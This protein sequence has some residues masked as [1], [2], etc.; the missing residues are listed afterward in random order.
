VDRFQQVK[1]QAVALWNSSYLGVDSSAIILIAGIILTTYL[2]RRRGPA[3]LI[4]AVGRV[5]PPDN[6]PS[7]KGALDTTRR[8]LEVVV[9]VTG[10]MLAARVLGIEPTNDGI[11]GL[12]IRSGVIIMVFWTLARLV[13]PMLTRSLRHFG[14]AGTELILRDFA[15][16][17]LRFLFIML[18]LSAVLEVWGIHIVGLVGSL[19]I[20]GAAVALG[21]RAFFSDIV[22]GIILISNHLFDRNDWIKTPELEGTVDRVGLRATRVRQFDKAL[23]T[24]PNSMLVDRALINFTRMTNRRIYW[25]IGLTYSTG[26]DQLKNIVKEISDYVHGN[27]GF[28]TNPDRVSTFVFVDSFGESSV[29]IM[30]YC[31]TKTTQWG[32]WLAVKEELAYNIK[33]IV[34]RNGSSFAFPSTSTYIESLPFGTPETLPGT[35]TALPPNRS[36]T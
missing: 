3:V 17:G 28:E 13:E 35:A 19:G 8:P 18:A 34:E 22:G 21:A 14:R 27:E 7:M 4:W 20:V 32:E 12:L 16:N 33:E 36:K 30:L 31:F 29:N 1:S 25:T 5:F 23:V 26:Q 10:F 9:L 24:V 15:I 2:L 6:H 11:Y